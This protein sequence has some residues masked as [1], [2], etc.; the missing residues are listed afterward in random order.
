[1]ENLLP[2]LP[3]ADFTYQHRCR[4]DAVMQ[5]LY[6]HAGDSYTVMLG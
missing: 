5:E 2:D 4:N 1:M 6:I 3:A